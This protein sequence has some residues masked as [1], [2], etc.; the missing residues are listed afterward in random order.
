MSSCWG[1]TSTTPAPACTADAERYRFHALL[2]IDD[3]QHGDPIPV[4]DLA[5]PRDHV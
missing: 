1:W 3:I 4:P 2:D 5:V